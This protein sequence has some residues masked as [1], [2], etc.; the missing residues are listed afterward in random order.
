MARHVAISFE[1][2]LVRVVY[3]SVRRGRI[4]IQKTLTIR[5]E[6]FD[7][8]L[9]EEKTGHFTVACDFNVFYQDVLLLPPVKDK[10]LNIIVETEMKKKFPDLGD[11][12]FFYAVIGE[13]PAEGRKVR[14]VFIFAVNNEDL[15]RIIERFGNHGKTVRQ[16]YPSPFVLAYFAKMSGTLSDEPVLCVGG[17]GTIKTLFLMKNR[18]LHFVRVVQSSGTGIYG[19]DIQNINMTASYCRQSKK[20]N[21]LQI[22]LLGAASRG[23]EST[24]DMIAPVVCADRLPEVVTSDGDTAEYIVPITALL[25]DS[26]IKKGS[27]VPQDYRTMLIQKSLLTWC[28]IFFVFFSVCGFGYIKIRLSDIASLKSGIESLASEIKAMGPIRRDYEMRYAEI[29][30]LMPLLDLAKSANSSPDTQKALMALQSLHMDN[31]N[32]RSIEISAAENV[33]NLQLKGDIT[34]P[35]YTV[36]Q[37]VY[38]NLIDAM[39]N[40]TGIEVVSQRIDLKDK[41]FQIEARY[42]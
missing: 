41:S 22:I 25:P 4:V 31:V 36:M 12:S 32:M 6:A 5:D 7:D 26:E 9:E 28:I 20:V 35:D 23:Y 38:Q 37:K 33:L 1:N 11:F 15:F 21:P 14:E 24:M 13:T 40:T 2:E 39:K 30:K 29:Q 10:Y 19:A 16:L 8:F 34:A 17:A 27:I 42:R 3:A 18:E